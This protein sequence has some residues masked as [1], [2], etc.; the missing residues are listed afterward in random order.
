[1]VKIALLSTG[2][3]LLSEKTNHNMF[4]VSKKLSAIGLSLSS[5]TI[6]PDDKN[7]I[8]QILEK[9]LDIYDIIIV[10]GGLGPTFDDLTV[11]SLSELLNKKL[12][13][14]R[15]VSQNIVR[16][17]VET[18][19]DV[20]ELAK[21]QAYVIDDAEVFIN[22]LG[23]APGQ[24]ISYKKKIIYLL[25]G[26][27]KEFSSMFDEYIF[28]EL[29][30]F[31]AGIS[32]EC[33]L[34]ICGMPESKIEEIISPVVKMEQK[35]SSDIH[36]SLIPYLN[37]VDIKISVTGKNELIVDEELQIVKK[38]IYDCFK[39]AG[40]G[41]TVIY[42]EDK[43]SL[44]FITGSL[45]AKHKKTLAVAESCT[46]GLLGHRITQIP[47]SSLYFLGSIVAYS[48]KVKT[49]ILKVKTET[50]ETYGAVSEETVK[51]KCIRVKNLTNADYCISVSGIAGPGGGTPE[52]P[53]GT[54]WIC[55]YDG[56][57]FYTKKYNLKGNRNEIKEQTVNL[58]LDML[59]K[60]ILGCWN[61]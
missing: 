45:L 48:N 1:M 21:K 5:A 43:I 13:I 9:Y 20:P 6:V 60:I 27:T 24:K 23:L 56:K 16:H 57:N 11:E 36:F 14:H 38:E 51:E 40:Y 4:Y 25:P 29:K 61:G 3:E 12:V 10:T 19:K 17:F 15:E 49:E 53:V 54:V 30:K 44:E 47:G 31:Q 7:A 33:V 59:R 55:I 46:G 8:K 26:P 34:H 28:P 42:A 18:N 58:C 50:L 35:F 37:I 32:K 22:K 2:N 41:E 52:K 39:K